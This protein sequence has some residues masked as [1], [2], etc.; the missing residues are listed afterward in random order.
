ML[1]APAEWGKVAAA[2]AEEEAAK[3]SAAQ[4]RSSEGSNAAAVG[5]SRDSGSDSDCDSDSGGCH[6]DSQQQPIAASLAKVR[7][8][9]AWEAFISR[10]SW[11]P[12][13]RKQ[14]SDMTSPEVIALIE[15]YWHDNTSA[16]PS[17]RD[18]RRLR[19]GR[20]KLKFH[21]THFQFKK[22][23]SACHK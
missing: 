7:V 19:L 13:G 6:D 14:R 1:D 16:S 8:E 18:Y 22:V 2:R 20:G 4:A 15:K 17:E 21:Q 5:T 23:S 9:A 3:A 11:L 10:F 12:V